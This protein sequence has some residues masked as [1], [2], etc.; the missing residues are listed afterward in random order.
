MNRRT[1]Y[2]TLK[3][4]HEN[5]G[6]YNHAKGDEM[7]VIKLRKA[8]SANNGTLAGPPGN[9]YPLVVPSSRDYKPWDALQCGGYE[10]L[11]VSVDDLTNTLYIRPRGNRKLAREAIRKAFK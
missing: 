6:S 3:L 7:S 4:A 9:A 11:V 8:W 5:R 2:G 1:C 10:W